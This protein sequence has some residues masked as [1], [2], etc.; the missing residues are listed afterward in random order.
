[1]ILADISTAR[2]RKNNK[3]K[4]EVKNL[5]GVEKFLK[6]EVKNEQPID[7]LLN[8]LYWDRM[9]QKII[10][11]VEARNGNIPPWRISISSQI[12]S[13]LKKVARSLPFISAYT[14]LNLFLFNSFFKG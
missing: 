8:E 5:R 14:F 4:Q 6:N 7:D 10:K 9:H 12:T 13:K 1:M 3:I 2:R 11:E